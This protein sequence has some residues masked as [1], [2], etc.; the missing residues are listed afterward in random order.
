MYIVFGSLIGG[1]YF[2][3]FILYSVGQT[4]G[5][6]LSLTALVFGIYLMTFNKESKDTP[7]SDPSTKQSSATT[8]GAL[9]FVPLPAD[10]QPC[11]RLPAGWQPCVPLS[12]DRQPCVPPPVRWQLPVSVLVRIMRV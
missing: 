1:L 8:H 4:V 7:L 12:A 3:D 2:D 11:V 9:P 6:S 10:R 5:W